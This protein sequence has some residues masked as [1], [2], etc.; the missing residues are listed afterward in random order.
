MK[1]G[2]YDYVVKS[3]DYLEDIPNIIEKA[4]EKTLF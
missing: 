2:A 1:D 3:F 4:Y